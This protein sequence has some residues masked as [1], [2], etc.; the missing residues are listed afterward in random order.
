MIQ[1][2]MILTFGSLANS[3]PY[4]GGILLVIVLAWLGAARS[5]D[6][7]FSVLA[8]EELRQ[9]KEATPAKAVAE[10][11]QQSSNGS[12]GQDQKEE[13]IGNGS[14]RE[15]VTG[16]KSPSSSEPTTPHIQ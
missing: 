8:K 2:F 11:S 3:T 7:Q 1:Q 14:V 15:S 12:I 5:L 9:E 4:L 16:G 6:S 10:E 13:N